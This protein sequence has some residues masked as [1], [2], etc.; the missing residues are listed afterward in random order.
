M[1]SSTDGQ[2]PCHFIQLSQSADTRAKC[3]GLARAVFLSDPDLRFIVHILLAELARAKPAQVEHVL[4]DHNSPDTIRRVLLV[5]DHDPEDESLSQIYIVQFDDPAQVSKLLK[6][7]PQLG[8]AWKA[9]WSSKHQPYQECD[10]FQTM[11]ILVLLPRGK[12]S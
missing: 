5:I 2:P 11:P 6:R 12:A 8:D 3:Q 4:L 7:Q 1:R 9:S 10:T